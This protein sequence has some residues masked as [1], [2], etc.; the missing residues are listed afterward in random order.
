[1]VHAAVTPALDS[2]NPFIKLSQDMYDLML[3]GCYYRIS[4]MIRLDIQ[5]ATRH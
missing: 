1:V 2:L 4:N 3:T 5:H